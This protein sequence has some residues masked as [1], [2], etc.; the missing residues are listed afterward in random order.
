MIKYSAGR[1]FALRRIL[2]AASF[3]FD[4]E[5]NVVEL[6]LLSE[7]LTNVNPFSIGTVRVLSS[8]A[9]APSRI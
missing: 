6:K 5:V 9:A 1:P 2:D 7:K 8:H 3:A 4:K